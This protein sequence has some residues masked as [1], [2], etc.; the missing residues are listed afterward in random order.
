MRLCEYIYRS[1]N[2]CLITLSLSL[3]LSF[4]ALPLPSSL[5]LSLSYD[6]VGL[7]RYSSSG[8]G[9]SSLFNA[10]ITLA[11]FI[12]ALVLQLRYFT[13]FFAGVVEGTDSDTLTHNIGILF[14]RMASFVTKDSQRMS[15][16]M[17]DLERIEEEE[18]GVV[19]EHDRGVSLPISITVYKIILF[20]IVK[21]RLG[22]VSLWHLMWRFLQLHLHKAIILSL[23]GLSLH[24]VSASY[25]LLVA[26]VLI[27][28]AL[29]I[30]NRVVYP[31][32]TAY[33]GLLTL[34]KF[35]F[36]L[37]IFDTFNFKDEDDMECAVRY[38]HMMVTWYAFILYTYSHDCY[39]MVMSV[40]VYCLYRV[41]HY[42]TSHWCSIIHTLLPVMT[43]AGLDSIKLLASQA[44]LL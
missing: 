2:L 12:V 23:F 41:P 27:T 3:P 36:Q 10:L 9:S 7:L 22:I 32:V 44:T 38:D 31:L 35:L 42:Q 30:I 13:P 6:A 8:N 19:E 40:H 28:T 5:F 29:P 26:M 25:L 33:L 16:I 43:A 24:E 34:G 20:V 15:Q 14:N 37:S 11:I 4:P 39:M 17:A 18:E 21:L 1:W